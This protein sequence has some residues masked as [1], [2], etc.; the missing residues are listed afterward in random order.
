MTEPTAAKAPA[1]ELT[2]RL[3]T[4]LSGAVV[5]IIL[6]ISGGRIGVALL[7]A[8]MSVAMIYE[9][10]EMTFTLPDRLEKRGLLM[11]LTWLLA[12][13][14]F[15]IPR[16]EYELFLICFFLLFS[17][18]LFTA[19]RHDG[20]FLNTH[21]QELMYS[22]F[23]VVYLGFLPL[24]LVLMRDLNNGVHWTLLFLL[25]VFFGDTGAYFAGKKWGKKK[26]YPFI[27]PK[28]TQ[29]GAL[30]GLALAILVTLIYKL[31][32][33][34]ALSWTGMVMIPLIVGI[35]AP[36]GDLAESF[37]KRAFNKKDSGSILPGHGG[38]LD[39]FDGV[40]WSAPIM[41]ACIRIFG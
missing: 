37:L 26:L 11:G 10:V 40:I 22:T 27:S 36:V 16:A 12:F 39:R 5:L 9:F 38:F 28:K 23:G 20:D 32:F 8:V 7:A 21:F 3:Q 24:F 6:I 19:Q 18:F 4:G 30:G 31:I 2:R 1:S 15:W 17:Y 29:E 14:N 41:Y 34:S 25:I 13:V 33:F 35:A